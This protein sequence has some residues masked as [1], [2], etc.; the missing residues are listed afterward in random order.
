M[1]KFLRLVDDSIVNLFVR[2][3]KDVS[4]CYHHFENR[5]PDSFCDCEFHS[6]R[7]CFPEQ[8][9]D[10]LVRIETLDYGKQIVL[11][12][13]QRGACNLGCEI[14]R[15]ALAESKKGLAVLEDDFQSPPLGINPVC[16]EEVKRHVRGYESVPG[17]LF[18][19]SDK[20]ETDLR[21]RKDDI[22]RGIVAFELAAVLDL[23]SCLKQFDK[24]RCGNVF[25]FK[26]VFG[27]SFLSNLD[28][29]KIIAAYVAAADETY[30]LGASEPAVGQDV[31]ETYTLPYGALDHVNGKFN[32][33]EAVFSDAFLNGRI[34]GTGL[35]V[36]GIEF[37]VRHAE[38]FVLSGFA[39]QCKVKHH[40]ADTVRYG[41]RQGL[42][43]EN[44]LVM[45]MGENA[46][47]E[48][49]LLACLTEVR[50][51]DYQAGG[52]FL[53]VTANTD[54]VPK[55]KCDL[56]QNPAPVSP[57]IPGETVE[58]ILNATDDAT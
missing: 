58:H 24:R 1:C 23:L 26:P 48:F 35:A 56:I 55:L 5:T 22:G 25:A 17:T 51:I 45:D 43:T 40:L 34:S 52:T 44:G 39:H 21:A 33:A 32:L 57:G 16:I 50:I 30:D 15:L 10:G 28:H 9:A 38:I 4:E 42:E 54:L 6:P 46:P 12:C 3:V 47:H 8:C 37:P 27:A 14:P 53:V 36:S 13:G 31:A 41:K 11:Y 19:A 18:A 29:S 2:K 7:A 49:E 20:E